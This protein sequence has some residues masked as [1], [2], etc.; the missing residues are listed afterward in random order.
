MMCHKKR[1]KCALNK[2]RSLII[3]QLI[4]IWYQ[5]KAFFLF[6]YYCLSTHKQLDPSVLAASLSNESRP[7]VNRCH[8]LL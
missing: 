6:K 8:L 4:M 1:Y 5:I 3:Y 7:L 2:S